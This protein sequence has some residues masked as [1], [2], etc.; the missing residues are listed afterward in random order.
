MDSEVAE[1]VIFDAF[2][3]ALKELQPALDI[4]NELVKKLGVKPM[5][6]ELS[7]PAEDIQKQVDKWLS[8]KL[9]KKV[10]NWCGK[11]NKWPI[12]FNKLNE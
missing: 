8:G 2:E 12:N 3:L 10:R 1:E 11:Y 6:F 5:E 4:Q 7:L 9:G